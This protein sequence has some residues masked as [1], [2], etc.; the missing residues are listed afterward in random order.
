VVAS[1][2]HIDA[3]QLKLNAARLV[4]KLEAYGVTGRVDE[5]HPG[6]VVTMYEFEPK[7]GTKISKIAGLSDDLAMSLAAQKVRI[8]APIPGKARVGFELPN[9]VRQTVSLR[10]ILEDERW[11]KQTGPLPIALGKDIAGQPYYGDLS[12]M[13]HLLV[14]GSRHCSSSARPRKCAC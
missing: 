1:D 12:K 8:V 6:P 3:G 7:S 10:Q 4:E 5:I 11:E 9:A 13:P 14:A 2:V